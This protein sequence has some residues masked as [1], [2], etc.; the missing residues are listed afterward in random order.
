[1]LFALLSWYHAFHGKHLL[2]ISPGLPPFAEV[3]ADK[4]SRHAERPVCMASLTLLY[5][6]EARAPLYDVAA[7]LGVVSSRQ[8][9]RSKEALKQIPALGF[10]DSR[11]NLTLMV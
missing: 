7:S 10:Q 3:S 9:L 8:A 1:M 2:P 11:S 4:S 5:P 6:R